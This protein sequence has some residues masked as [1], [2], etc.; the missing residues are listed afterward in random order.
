MS[1]MSTVP[2]RGPAIDVFFKLGGGRFQ[3]HRQRPQGPRHRRFLQPQRWLLPD[4]PTTPLKGATIDIFFKLSG[5]HY[6]TR[7]Q[8]P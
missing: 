7:R 1:D 6:Q 3:T 4:P 8:R 2:S 5:G